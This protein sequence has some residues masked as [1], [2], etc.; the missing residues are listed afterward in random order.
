MKIQKMLFGHPVANDE[1]S[2]PICLDKTNGYGKYPA[3]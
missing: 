3:G 2:Y 1:T